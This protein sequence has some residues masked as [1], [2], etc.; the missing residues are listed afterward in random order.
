MP[1]DDQ[2]HGMT[3]E[4]LRWNGRG[5]VG[6]SRPKLYDKEAI[7]TVS[8]GLKKLYK[9]KR[10]ALWDISCFLKTP[11]QTHAPSSALSLSS[12]GHVRD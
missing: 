12:T 7:R 11:C 10:N 8:L 2:D 6:L 5:L 9:S 1:S 4:W 3:T